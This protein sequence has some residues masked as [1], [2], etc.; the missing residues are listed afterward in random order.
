M[1]KNSQVSE[2]PDT[3]KDLGDARPPSADIW[4]AIR[5]C[6]GDRSLTPE[7]IGRADLVREILEERS[8]R[9][10]QEGRKRHERLVQL[11]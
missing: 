8:P 11:R 5:L 6:V 9:E 4:F 10:L 2:I 1:V 7:G 3:H